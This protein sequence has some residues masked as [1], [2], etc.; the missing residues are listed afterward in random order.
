MTRSR[1]RN[2]RLTAAASTD[3]IF[4]AQSAT[5]GELL[6]E[7]PVTA[8]C[9]S[10]YQPRLRVL[11]DAKFSALVDSVRTQGVLQPVLVLETGPDEFQ[12]LAGE[13]RLAAAKRAGLP[14]TVTAYAMR[15]SAITDLV[16]GGLDLL[17][18]AQ[19]SG[20]SVAMIERHYGHLRADHAAAALATL[21][22]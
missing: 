4:S 8:L 14:D 5:S 12:L 1:L 18:V 17:T 21:A 22:L 11:D 15:H 9:R 20:T 19:L 3:A 10:V 6:R 16:T 2:P 7:L 13:R